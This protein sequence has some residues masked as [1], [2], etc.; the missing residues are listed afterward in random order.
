MEG[1]FITPGIT[2]RKVLR[3]YK[4]HDLP[5][6]VVKLCDRLGIG[7][8]HVDFSSK[9]ILSAVINQD[10]VFII[11]VSKKLSE[12]QA[13]FHVAIELGHYYLH[14]DADNPKQAVF[15][16]RGDNSKKA[17]EAR[18]FASE[19]LIPQKLMRKEY[20]KM[21]VPVSNSLAKK[22][23]VPKSEICARLDRLKLMYI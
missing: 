1:E 5:I 17:V 8:R 15:S 9:E 21:I 20:S 7:I 18:K 2:A 3:K 16:F 11:F 19:L 13:R 22:F 10:G 23:K 14:M 12:V 4:L 6:D